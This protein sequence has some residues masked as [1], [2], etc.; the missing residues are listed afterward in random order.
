MATECTWTKG[1]LKLAIV[2]EKRPL[3]RA[4]QVWPLPPFGA[5]AAALISAAL[6]V[7]A[8]TGKTNIR[9]SSL[10]QFGFEGG[11]WQTWTLEHTWYVG[12]APSTFTW[13]SMDLTP[14]VL[15]YLIKG[16]QPGATH[17]FRVV[18]AT[19]VG[20]ARTRQVYPEVSVSVPATAEVIR[21]DQLAQPL[22]D[23]LIPN[24][25]SEMGAAATGSWESVL[26]VNDP[27]NAY[28]G[29]WCRRL[30]A[31][32]A[33]DTQLMD[34][35]P[36][37]YGDQHSFDCYVKGSSATPVLQ[38]YLKYV[39]AAGAQVGL[40]PSTAYTGSTSQKAL[41]VKGAVPAGAVGVQPWVKAS[42]TAAS[43]FL[44]FDQI[45]LRR[46]IRPWHMD[47]DS[48][49]RLLNG[50]KNLQGTGDINDRVFYAGNN[51]LSV[52]GGSP[53]IACLTVTP[54]KWD[55]TGHTGLV[56]FK[57][58]PTAANDNLDAM[59]P[60]K[61]IIYSQSVPYVTSGAINVTLTKGSPNTLTR[62]SGG[63]GS[64]VTDG[65]IAGM[66]NVLLGGFAN[67][68]NNVPV[69]LSSVTA[70]QITYIL[71]SSVAETS[72]AGVSVQTQPVLTSLG[73]FS[74]STQ[75]RLYAHPTDSN[76]ANA[77]TVSQAV[78]DAGLTGGYAA[79][80][81]TLNNAS[82]PS[83][84][85]CFYA[86]PTG[87][88]GVALVD[89]G[90]SYPST[91][92]GGT[93]GG[94]GVGGGGGGS[95]PAPWVLVDLPEGLQ[96]PAG[97]VAVGDILWTIHPGTG[98]IGGWPVLEVSTDE[99]DRWDVALEGMAEP[100]TF[101]PTHP[102]RTETGWCHV[103]DLQPDTLILGETPRRVVSVA[104]RDR[105]PVVK[106]TVDRAHSYQTSGILSSNIKP[107]GN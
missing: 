82:G 51:D 2:T 22:S 53:N 48:G 7:D 69:T 66:T 99:S 41:S 90:A 33:N 79:A 91:F 36:C 57:I 44:Y 84:T 19:Q 81:V 87:A 105:G 56:D 8:S 47:G 62:N 39:N 72:R 25:T 9:I 73:T 60:T 4:R 97:D 102:L 93:A 107:V 5:N 13:D 78:A 28:A 32:A 103:Q 70:T 42:T 92:S 6:E 71:A 27:A 54:Q 10:Q 35:I 74:V 94:T 100:L 83:D 43:S 40:S 76:A 34:T 21:T 101:A 11:T 106:I 45:S 30:D 50:L 15:S 17:K 95:C 86:G 96:K 1:G 3:P 85:H 68:A 104:Y 77:S 16:P 18:L 80:T 63:S 37:L 24:P 61:A 23:N 64:F 49:F 59:R 88:A 65:F 29:N 98:T 55:S 38:L 26:L 89:G 75:D 14:G 52:R 12:A 20:G 31:S 46:S 58:Q 67:S